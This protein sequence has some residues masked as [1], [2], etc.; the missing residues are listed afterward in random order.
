MYR[1]NLAVQYGSVNTRYPET[2]GSPTNIIEKNVVI[3][4]K[5]KNFFKGIADVLFL[6]YSICS[7]IEEKTQWEVRA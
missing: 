7:T 5:S 4:K 2:A 3:F 6:R 1:L